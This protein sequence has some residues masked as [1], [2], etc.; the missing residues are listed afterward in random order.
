MGQKTKG[1]NM[2]FTDRGPDLEKVTRIPDELNLIEG[3]AFVKFL[4]EAREHLLFYKWC[5]GVLEEYVGA[6]YE[7]IVGIFLFRISPKLVGVDEWVWVVVGD[8]PPTYLT[9][10]DS[11]N[12][13]EALESYM[14]A[15]MEWV[16]AAEKGKSVAQLVPVNVPATP[17]NAASLRA[18]LRFLQQRIL[19]EIRKELG[20]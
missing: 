9:C 19:P 4:D 14:G 3:T 8:L 20:V 11:P 10:E 5:E 1:A 7:G 18:R 6:Y 15:M 17:E 16:E 13:A 2:T 12:P